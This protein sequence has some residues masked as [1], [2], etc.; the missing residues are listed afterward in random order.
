M[1]NLNVQQKMARLW[2]WVTVILFCLIILAIIIYFANQPTA[3][4]QMPSTTNPPATQ[5]TTARQQQAP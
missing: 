5:D 4:R 2:V 1:S 3:E